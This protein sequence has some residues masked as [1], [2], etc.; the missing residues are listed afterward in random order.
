MN[1]V[2]FLALLTAGSLATLII[3]PGCGSG[4]ASNAGGTVG[5]TD[6]GVAR[7]VTTDAVA[8]RDAASSDA[9]V[10]VDS[11]GDDDA[12]VPGARA[13]DQ[14][15]LDAGNSGD[16]GLNRECIRCVVS[17]CVAEFD[18]CMANC[19]CNAIAGELVR[20][21]E[22]SGQLLV[23]GAPAQSSSNPVVREVVQCASQQPQCLGVCG[24]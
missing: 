9:R 12:C 22:S 18:R 10:A 11:S 16:G 13:L 3:V 6:A 7:D 15:D 24:L 2:R 21:L 4:E 5:P 17:G 8:P 20:C 23:C 1:T 19:V 14:V